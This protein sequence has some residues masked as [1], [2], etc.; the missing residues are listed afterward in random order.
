MKRKLLTLSLAVLVAGSSAYAF[1]PMGGKSFCGNKM[2]KKSFMGYK[3]GSTI[4]D[5][6]AIVSDMQLSNKQWIEIKKTML[7]IKEQRLDYFEDKNI[8]TIKIDENGVFDK[9]AFIKDRMA[10]SKKMIN[11]QASTIEK[12][13]DILDVSQKKILI[14]KLALK[15]IE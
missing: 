5:V 8:F 9:D 1:G 3:N 14:K 7:D 10:Y 13:L 12:I 11:T 4:F 15:E 2:I 6:M